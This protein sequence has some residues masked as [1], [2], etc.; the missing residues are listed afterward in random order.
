MNTR[1]HPS[2]SQPIDALI[3]QINGGLTEEGEVEITPA[4]AERLRAIPLP[5]ADLLKASYKERSTDNEEARDL[6]SIELQELV[7]ALIDGR[8]II[9]NAYESCVIHPLVGGRLPVPRYLMR[10]VD[11][12]ENIERYNYYPTGFTSTPAPSEVGWI[13]EV[14]DDQ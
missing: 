9:E 3:G 7:G 6:R 14:K 10:E 8:L 2:T 5:L 12:P 13:V 4:I 1:E 11:R